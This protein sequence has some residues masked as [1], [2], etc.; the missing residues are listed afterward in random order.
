MFEPDK[1]VLVYRDLGELADKLR[2]Y[3][4][5]PA[6]GERIRAAG[7][8]RALQEHTYHHRFQTL[9]RYLNLDQN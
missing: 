2:Y 4:A 9:F 7:R 3:L 8:H 6:A 5:T 1:E